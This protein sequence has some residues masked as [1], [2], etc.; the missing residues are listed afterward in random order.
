MRSALREQRARF[1]DL[2]L[3]A[4]TSSVIQRLRLLDVAH[5]LEAAGPAEIL[6]R[7]ETWRAATLPAV[8][9]GIGSDD[10]E[11]AVIELRSATGRLNSMDQPDGELVAQIRELERRV[12]RQSMTRTA[13]R[14]A[15]EEPSNPDRSDVAVQLQQRLASDRGNA[16]GCVDRIHR[17]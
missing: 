12:R 16:Q 1:A 2:E 11:R 10:V 8:D 4:H 3:R 9:A 15:G 6:A 5:A 14:S 7:D 13:G 17:A